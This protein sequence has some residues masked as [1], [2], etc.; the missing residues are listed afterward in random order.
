MRWMREALKKSCSKREV[1]VEKEYGTGRMIE[2]KC[3]HPTGCD[4]MELGLDDASTVC[5]CHKCVRARIREMN[6]ARAAYRAKYATHD[7]MGIA[8]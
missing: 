1:P 5:T 4:C 6:K 8:R 2:C 7:P 3:G